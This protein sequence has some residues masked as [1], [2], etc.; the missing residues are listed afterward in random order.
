MKMTLLWAND[1]STTMMILTF[2]FFI[3]KVRCDVKPVYDR[4]TKWTAVHYKV[5]NRQ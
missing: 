2:I 3:T 1:T 4:I 5:Q